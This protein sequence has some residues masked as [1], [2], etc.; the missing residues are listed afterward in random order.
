MLQHE[1]KQFKKLISESKSVLILLAQNPKGDYFCSALALAYLCEA[2][3]IKSTIAFHDPYKQI[4]LFE[5]LPKPENVEFTQS[6]AGSRDLILTFNTKYNKILDIKTE[7]TDDEFKIYITPEK[8]M[9]DSRDF[10][11]VPGKFPYDVIVTVGATNKEAMG[12]LYEEIPDIFFELPII[13]IDNK[14]DNEQFGQIN[15]VNP[16]TSSVSELV[17]NLLEYLY[18]GFISKEC[19]ECVLA[20]IIDETRSFQ[21]NKTTPNAMTLASKLIEYGADQQMIVQNL[22]RNL[23]FSLLQLWGRVL[24]NFQTSKRNKKV[25]ISSLS[26]KDIIETNAKEHHIYGI[27]SKMKESYPTGKIFILLYEY[28]QNQVI[29][30]IDTQYANLDIRDFIDEKFIVLPNEVYKITLNSQ[31]IDGAR[32]KVCDMIAPYLKY[33]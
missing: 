31:T 14:T 17:G 22:Y 7:Q 11:F 9:I 10:S 24:K 28:K 16:V 5:F 18:G 23:P 26:H 13:N 30:L 8:G 4:S 2:K 27:L 21:N 25:I 20:G 6:I 29:A 32:E 1:M 12:K 15:I 19:A 33:L 3:N